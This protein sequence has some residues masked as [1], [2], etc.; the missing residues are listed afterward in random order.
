MRPLS[1]S[2]ISLYMQCPLKYKFRYIDGLKEK[3][4]PY[5]SFGKSV[6]QA[7]E[8]F[9]GS[10]F[11]A[12]PKLEEVLQDYEK[13]WLKE[14]YAG[15]DEEK[16]YFEH[17]KIV[18]KDFYDKHIA[19]YKRPLAVEHNIRFE[20]NG[21]KV[22]AVIDRIDKI[23]DKSVEVIDYK[24]NKN[25]FNLTELREEP[26]LSMYQLA[27]EQEMGFKVEK[28][29]YYHLLSQT[30]FTIERHSEDN[31]KALKERVVEVARSIENKEFPYKENRF[32]PCDF[33]N[34]C[35]LFSHEHKVCTA[36]EPAAVN[37]IEVIDQYGKLKDQ[38]KELS[39]RI[40]VLQ[41][42]IKQYM[43]SEGLARVFGKDY[44]VTKSKTTQER[45]DTTKAKQVL[46]EYN[47]LEDLIKFIDSV[48]IRYKSR[49]DKEA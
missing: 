11:P 2:S 10:K 23:D 15:P 17:G 9:F 19:G 41:Q 21:V 30:P 4:R 34:L 36:K 38:D 14:G 8:Y 45:L 28:L 49:K 27:I 3:P 22:V 40:D 13:N 48:T 33:G 47:L 25:P 7:L 42:D 16:K 12:P 20:V 44:E 32:C 18:I 46:K 6:H 37:I 35:P 26:Q 5:L 39:V 43:D 24:T 1:H 31:I 29:T